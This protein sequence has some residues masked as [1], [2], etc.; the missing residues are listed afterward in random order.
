MTNGGDPNVDPNAPYDWSFSL[1]GDD[2][3][4]DGN[5]DFGYAY[6]F[7]DTLDAT[8]AGWWIGD[9]P[10][11][12]VGTTND[13]FDYEL[14]QDPNLDPNDPN[15][16][17]FVLSAWWWFGGTPYAQAFL[18]MWAVPFDEYACPA[19]C[20]TSLD[21]DCDVDMADLVILK[22]ALGT[23]EGD[24]GYLPE[25]DFD[26]SGCIDAADLAKMTAQFGNVC[27]CPADCTTSLDEDC[28][29][30][31]DD[32]NI[33]LAAY[34]ACPGDPDYNPDADFTDPVCVDFDDLNLLLSQYNNN[35]RP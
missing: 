6:Y 2:I 14:I 18:R 17:Y 15:A 13:Y 7:I 9:D 11:G 10:N 12:D 28:D 22:A 25:A 20:S 4:L 16:F 35:C 33:L 30:D 5:A 23:C 27:A 1:D 19:E 32:L 21:H 31:F 3:D 26:D 34:N 29:V 24:P 8:E